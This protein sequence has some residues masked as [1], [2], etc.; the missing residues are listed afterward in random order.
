MGGHSGAGA[1]RADSEGRKT[2]RR[3]LEGV[4]RVRTSKRVNK[5]GSDSM[6]TGFVNF[7]DRKMAEVTRSKIPEIAGKKF[8]MY[9]FGVH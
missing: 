7:G 3:I 6:G 5:V 8:E 1:G 2:G 9:Q 4:S